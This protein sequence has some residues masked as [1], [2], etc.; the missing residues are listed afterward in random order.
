MVTEKGLFGLSKRD[1]LLK[2]LSVN[3]LLA[4]CGNIP[5]SLLELMQ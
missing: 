1:N 2:M 4:K 3:R 5:L